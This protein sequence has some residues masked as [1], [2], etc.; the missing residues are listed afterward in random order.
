MSRRNLE[1]VPNP[2]R[3]ICSP[4]LIVV[5]AFIGSR[6]IYYALGVR[7]DSSVL[8]QAWQYL[9]VNL[10]RDRLAESLLNLHSQPPL[11]NLFLGLVVKCFPEHTNAAFHVTYLGAGLAL[12]LSLLELME[13]LKVPA[14]LSVALTVLYVIS[15]TTVLYENMLLYDYPVAVLLVL[16]ALSLAHWSA[17]RGIV[18]GLLFFLLLAV[19]V[20]TRSVFQPIWTVVVMG[21][22]LIFSK[23]PGKTVLSA[24]AL[25]L[26]LVLAWQA[27]N[28]HRFGVTGTSSWLGMN[29]S[30]NTVERLPR[31]VLDRLIRQGQVSP[32][33]ALPAF[34]AFDQY[35]GFL[36]EPRLTHVPALD[37]EFKRPPSYGL[38]YNYLG[39]ITVSRVRLR[40][41]LS[42]IESMPGTY[43][44][45]VL[46]AAMVYFSPSGQYF[47]GTANAS[48]IWFFERA[49]GQISASGP[50]LRWQGCLILLWYGIA[51]WYGAYNL[52]L[53]LGS[54]TED[55]VVCTVTAFMWLTV[56]YTTVVA[57]L[58][59]VWENQRLR[60]LVDPLAWA[61]LGAFMGELLRARPLSRENV[62]RA[63]H[64]KTRE[65]NS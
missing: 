11:F 56:C 54:R 3:W 62:R 64:G 59:D 10:L 15:P 43:A 42:A 14:G 55:R 36:P 19:I 45:H 1:P 41:A 60:F 27:H 48:R 29:M 40:D 37:Q 52:G 39:Y 25:P 7:F 38:N 23:I 21:L 30:R 46:D 34:G 18:P 57:N 22:V 47:T 58:T 49:W 32:A 20:L 35:R 2:I 33:A 28:F 16:A 26:A 31:E 8:Y 24:A 6:A 5:T 13:R 53:C 65:E 9:D 51:I 61:I 50:A 17:R 44:N 4:R 12:S 63:L